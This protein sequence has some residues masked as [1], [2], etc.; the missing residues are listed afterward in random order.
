MACVHASAT[1]AGVLPVDIEAVG[2]D[3][4]T[5]VVSPEGNDAG[6]G[7]EAEPL[8]TLQA[9]AD[10]VE[11]GDTVLVRE[12]TYTNDNDH[13]VVVL[14]RGGTADRWVRLA[15]FPG[16]T[17]V[18]R[19]DSLRGIKT[20]SASYLVIEGFEIDGRSDEVDPAAATVHA[21]AFQ[22][23]DHSQH[24]F[25]GVG[26][27]ISTSEAEPDRYGHHLIIRGNH[28][29]HTAGG[30]I[31]TARADYLL[32]ENN[33]IHHTSFY[34]PW[35]GSGISVWQSSNFDHRQDVY[36]TVIRN[37]VSY[38]NDNR[39]KFWMI[40][41]F[42]DGNGIILDALHNSQENIIGDGYTQKYDGRVLVANNVCYLNGGRS[43]NIYESDH[44]D[45]IHNTLL[46]N[47]QR[48]NIKNEI[49][50][51]RT[52]DTRIFNNLIDVASG[53]QAVG[54]YQSGDITMNHNLIHGT[55]GTDFEH[56]DDL[57]TQPPRLARF[58]GSADVKKLSQTTADRF[59]FRPVKQS[60]AVGA[61]SSD[62]RIPRDHVDTP[63]PEDRPAD[64]GAL[65][66]G[67]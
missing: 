15:N 39:V 26:I 53:K 18:I 25:F 45:L 3:G 57:V 33:R 9:A 42:S 4:R 12:G 31:A 62:Y 5:W 67:G 60:P 6:A 32:I 61:A 30:G 38:L 51:G 66:A 65:Q 8:Q 52:H 63:R 44:V 49:E 14:R 2:L 27:R 16:E 47:A 50:L 59:D 56:G 41:K 20:E 55:L 19:F 46:F 36:R 17:P 10:R 64:L 24:Q 11:P 1:P 7:T 29:H 13:A 21:E 34:T 54:G 28:V 40:Q 35:G 43:V 23:Q 22:G 37:N 58:P 48:D